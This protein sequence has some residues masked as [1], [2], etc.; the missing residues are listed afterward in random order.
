MPSSNNYAADPK[1]GAVAG[2]FR[3][4]ACKVLRTLPGPNLFFPIIRMDLH[5]FKTQ[6]LLALF[7]AV[8][9]E[10]RR[11]KT[12]RSTNNP[13][14]D[15]A[16][17]LVARAL[18]L[19][20]AAKSTRG[21]DAVDAEDRRYEIKGRRLTRQNK[22]TQLSAIRGL[23]QEYFTFLAGVLF[24]EDFSVRR[25]CLIPH[26]T[27]KKIATYR[28]GVNAWIVHLRDGVWKIDGVQ[29]ITDPLR[30]AQQAEWDST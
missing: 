16:E 20:L 26:E 4:P 30:E 1:R 29:D 24:N 27:V 14:A 12:I 3:P 15:Y 7:V 5:T 23:D 13:V 28:S 11:R 2:T 6:E 25:A 18:T 10:L 9:D 19:E 8:L 17:H 21:Y 22:S